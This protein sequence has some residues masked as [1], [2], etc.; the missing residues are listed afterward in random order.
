M[1][2]FAITGS[3]ALFFTVKLL[4][5]INLKELVSPIVFWPLRVIILFGI[6]QITLILVAIPFGEFNYFLKF[7]K[8]FLKR[9]GIKI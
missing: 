8:K 1:T 9:I 4:S 5:F 6:Y 3:L 7:I 2:V